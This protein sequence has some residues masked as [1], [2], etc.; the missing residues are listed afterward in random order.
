[1]KIVR[2]PAPPQKPSRPLKSFPQPAPA[3]KP[4][5]RKWKPLPTGPTKLRPP[6]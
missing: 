3:P 5:G 6:T 4:P 1:M 2:H